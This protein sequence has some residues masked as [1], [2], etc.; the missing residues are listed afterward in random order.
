MISPNQIIELLKKMH[1]DFKVQAEFKASLSIAGMDGTLRNRMK[2]TQ[3]EGKL[4]GKTGTLRGTRALAGYTT[5]A[6]GEALTFSMI[7]EHFVGPT[8]GIRRIQDRIGVILSSY[9][10]NGN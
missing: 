6:D 5:T 9:S 3:A 7:M 2:N 8:S 1:K 4:R 10:A